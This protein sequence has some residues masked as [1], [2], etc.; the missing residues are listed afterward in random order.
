M[1]RH[2]TVPRAILNSLPEEVAN[3]PLVRGTVGS[4]N[5]WQIPEG[6][7]KWI[8]GG[9]GIGGGSYNQWWIDALTGLGGPESATVADIVRLREAAADAFGL[10]PYKP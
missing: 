3:N 6:L 2:H 8:H 7:H 5:I 1:V 9:G 4:K 10:L